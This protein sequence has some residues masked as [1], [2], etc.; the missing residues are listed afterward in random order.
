MKKTVAVILFN[1]FAIFM[2][3]ALLEGAMYVLV[4]RPDILKRCPQGIRNSV[5]YLYSVGE[6]K[7]IQFSPDCARHD[8]ELGYTL[9]PGTCT[10]SAAEFNNRY[11]INRQGLRDDENSLDKPDVIVGGDSYAMGWGVEQEDTFAAV[12]EK[13]SG[14]KVLNTAV[15][16]YGTAREMIVLRRLDTTNLKF[17]IIQ[18]CEND[19]DENREFYLKGN[20]LVTMSPDE[21]RRYTNLNQESKDYYPG[22][23]LFLKLEKKWKELQKPEQSGEKPGMDKDDV[24]LF[25]NAVRNGPVGLSQVQIIVF[26]AVGKND[27]DRTFIRRLAEKIKNGTYPPPVNN[28][29]TLDITKI[30]TK[31]DYYVLDDHWKK[32]GHS[33]IADA[34]IKMVQAQT[35][36]SK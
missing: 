23:Y 12:L 26:E 4:R 1:L 33:A 10:F 29:I 19:F 28:M 8:A 35:S 22:K 25:I 27:F 3:L 24:D 18:Y 32:S 30:I 15:A 11:Q 9:K 13:K 5:G 34:L 16:S 2:V 20:R 31:D 36:K 6:R 14:L 7:V 17:L 21:Y